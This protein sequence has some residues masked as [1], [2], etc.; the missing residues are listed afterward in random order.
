MSESPRWERESQQDLRP[1]A[2][3]PEETIEFD[4]ATAGLVDPGELS[5][6]PEYGAAAPRPVSAER[7]E[8][9]DDESYEEDADD[10]EDLASAEETGR[11]LYAA[12]LE[13]DAQ[14]PRRLA[15]RESLSAT[16]ES[17]SAT[18]ESLA[19]T[20]GRVGR[21]FASLDRRPEFDAG[22]ERDPVAELTTTVA[23]SEV[24]V[25]TD[26]ATNPSTATLTGASTAMPT[27]SD[28]V[29]RPELDDEPEDDDDARDDAAG[30]RFP[31]AALGYNR[32]AVD[33][34]IAALETELER[35]REAVDPPVS[36]TEEIERLGEQTASILVVAHDKAHETARAAQAKAARAVTE[37][38][39]NAERITAEAQRRLRVLDEETDAVWRERERLLDDV[40]T[41]SAALASLADDAS[42]RFPAAPEPSM[43]AGQ[44]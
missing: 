28:G 15:V 22:S 37:A 2:H 30:S 16:R 5:E 39:H 13:E 24:P 40:R 8:R 23:T 19:D 6:P 3:T 31:T 29:L 26:P 17:L 35:L 43:S 44:G 4:M 34:R 1:P 20:A 27:M 25:A 33:Q 32:H 10:A 41:V 9:G 21:W 36:I 14:A 12:H 18:R 38:A 7:A 42:A 11:A